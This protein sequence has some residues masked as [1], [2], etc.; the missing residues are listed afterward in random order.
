VAPTIKWPSRSHTLR[1][2]HKHH[3]AYKNSTETDPLHR[4]AKVSKPKVLDSNDS[5]S[6]ANRQTI[7]DGHENSDHNRHQQH[8]RCHTFHHQPRHHSYIKVRDRSVGNAD[9][10]SVRAGYHI[11]RPG[12]GKSVQHPRRDTDYLD[13]RGPTGK[14][15]RLCGKRKRHIQINSVGNGIPISHAREAVK[16]RR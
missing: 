2:L 8:A 16:Q 4:K 14:C 13:I 11:H 3:Q 7:Q 6:S 15:H 1:L 10:A 5:Q 9:P 12:N